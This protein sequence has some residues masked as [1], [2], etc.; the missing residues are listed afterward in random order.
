MRPPLTTPNFREWTMSD[1]Y[2]IC[3]R[4]FAP[5]S[6][7]K[8]PKLAVL[9]LHG[10]QSHGAWFEWSASVLASCGVPVV[11]PDRRGSGLNSAGRGDVPALERW[12]E[13]VDELASWALREFSVKQIGVVGVSWGGKTAVALAVRRPLLVARLLLVT[14]GIFPAVDVGIGG[15]LAIAASLL[16]GGQ[17]EHPIPLSD[18]ALF[19]DNPEGR[20]FITRDALKL[21]SATARFL[22][23]SA[24]FDAQLRRLKPGALHVPTILALSEYDKII[25]NEATRRWAQRIAGPYMNIIL[26]RGQAHTLE[27]AVEAQTYRRLLEGWIMTAGEAG[28]GAK[29]PAT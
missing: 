18:A 28:S 2:R 6:A 29:S 8:P 15:R 9:Y 7:A 14:P 25:R 11:L 23:Q 12:N 5:A 16:A 26:V 1:G 4:V 17:G 19:T 3:G 13:D 24:R 20:A 10:I 27:F 21:E 22:F